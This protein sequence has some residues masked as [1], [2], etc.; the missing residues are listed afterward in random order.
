MGGDGTLIDCNPHMGGGVDTLIGI[1][2]TTL[3]LFD[4]DDEGE[5]EGESSMI[6]LLRSEND[7]GSFDVLDSP[8]ES[9]RKETFIKSSSSVSEPNEST[10][11]DTLE[12][13]QTSNCRVL[14][15]TT[16]CR[17]SL[18]S[19]SLS[20]LEDPNNPESS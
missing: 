9:K 7:P 16:I 5:G 18:S 11:E 14:P 3:I 17:S 2:D 1:G 6:F 20:L 15:G 12:P 8:L 4:G 10:S 13:K 19:L